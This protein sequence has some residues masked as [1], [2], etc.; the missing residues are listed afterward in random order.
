MKES[1]SS[2][3]ING[4]DQKLDQP[5]LSIIDQLCKSNQ[6]IDEIEFAVNKL[7]AYV[8]ESLTNFRESLTEPV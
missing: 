1:L 8:K 6:R 7:G 2:E 3:T 4:L 5:I